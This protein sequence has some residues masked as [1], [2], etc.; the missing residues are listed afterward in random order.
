[1]PAEISLGVT[2][3]LLVGGVVYSLWKSR[4]QSPAPHA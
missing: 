1:V 4:D 2:F 3:G